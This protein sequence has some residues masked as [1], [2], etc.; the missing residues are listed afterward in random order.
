MIITISTGFELF[1]VI[2]NCIHVR[3]SGSTFGEDDMMASDELMKPSLDKD[4][5]WQII[6]AIDPRFLLQLV[7]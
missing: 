6:N 3:Y 5:E 1:F 4:L 7:R 2:T